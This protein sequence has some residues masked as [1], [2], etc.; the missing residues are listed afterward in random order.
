MTP[1]TTIEF[2]LHLVGACALG[3]IVGLER[4]WH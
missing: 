1:V 3:G 2:V 4:Q